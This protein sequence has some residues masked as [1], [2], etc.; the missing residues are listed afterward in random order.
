[1][2]PTETP[3]EF[4]N[5]SNDLA[6]GFADA[7]GLIE[8]ALFFVVYTVLL[9]SAVGFATSNYRQYE[10]LARLV[11]AISA[12]VEY[13]LKGVGAVALLVLTFLPIYAV[14]QTTGETRGIVGYAIA[15]AILGYVLIT[16]IGY[17]ADR[18]YQRAREQ[19]DEY[20]APDPAGRDS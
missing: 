6:A 11:E 16:A 5:A 9:V 10:R 12:S 1:M 20:R 8:P 2:T 19:H 17:L 18:I 14:S 13:F 4:A 7:T 3:T 15:V